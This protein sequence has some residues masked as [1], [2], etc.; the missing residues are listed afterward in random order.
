[1]LF[2]HRVQPCL[3]G[4]LLG[5]ALPTHFLH[6]F[7]E[8]LSTSSDVDIEGC[9]LSRV[10]REAAEVIRATTVKQEGGRLEEAALCAHP[11]QMAR[12]M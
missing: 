5:G 3:S 2:P 12:A 6:Y 8:G 1:L 10:V 7:I 11:A 9:S 4:L